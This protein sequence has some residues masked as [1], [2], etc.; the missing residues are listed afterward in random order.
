MRPSLTLIESQLHAL[1]L[2]AHGSEP[3]SYAQLL[4]SISLLL[5]SF[6]RRRMQT[7]PNDIEDVVQEALLA[8]HQKRHTYDHRQSLTAWIYAIARYKW[9]D[10]LRMHGRHPPQMENIDDWADVLGT[11]AENANGEAHHDLSQMLAALPAKQS[12]A[13]EYTRLQGLSI[14][15]TARLTGQSQSAVKVNVHRGLRALRH[16]WGST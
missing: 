7:H 16:R 6:M 11:E 1:W 3:E 9:V 4:N 2:R 14:A 15:Q 8:I 12:M 13:I 10:H 5:R